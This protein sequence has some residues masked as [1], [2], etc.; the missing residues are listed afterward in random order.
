VTERPAIIKCRAGADPK[1]SEK[2]TSAMSACECALSDTG[3]GAKDQKWKS[4]SPSMEKCSKS[5]ESPG[6]VL[7]PRIYRGVA[8][9]VDASGNS[10]TQFLKLPSGRLEF[11][12]EI[13][14]EIS[15]ILF[16]PGSKNQF[17]LYGLEVHSELADHL[18]KARKWWGCLNLNLRSTFCQTIGSGEIY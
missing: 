12:S 13:C 8:M 16:A 15:W 3:S 11:C 4:R 9:D 7:K 18:Q 2:V 1:Q 17:K 6:R 14:T 10:Q 5:F